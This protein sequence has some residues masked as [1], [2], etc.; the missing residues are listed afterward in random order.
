MTKPYRLEANDNIVELTTHDVIWIPIYGL[1]MDPAYWDEPH[2][3]NPNRFSD[4]NRKN[5]RAGTYLP[6][7]SGQRT[8][9]A[10]RFAVMVAKTFF[11][12]LLRHILIAKCDK[13]ANPVI[14]KR[15]TINMHAE[16]GFWVRFEP[17]N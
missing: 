5:I 13:T 17:R 9:I 12:H 4:E 14:L 7:G 2:R 6:F 11:F 15:N 1:H 10:S 16:G 3:F 8:C